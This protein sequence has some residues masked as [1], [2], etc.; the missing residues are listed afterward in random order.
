LGSQRLLQGLWVV[1]EGFE[2]SFLSWVA[3]GKTLALGGK[4]GN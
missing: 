2:A 3:D 4:A 1:E